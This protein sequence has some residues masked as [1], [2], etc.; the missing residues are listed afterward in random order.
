MVQGGEFGRFGAAHRVI[1]AAVEARAFPAA[2]VEV[3]DA[4]QVL[5]SEALGRLTFDADAPATRP[6]TVFDLASLTKVLS[7]TSIVMQEVERGAIGLDEP[8]SQ[9]IPA[10]TG[11]DR[12]CVTVRDLLAHSSGLPAHRHFYDTMSGRAAIERAVCATP[13]EYEPGTR[14][15]YSDLGFM[16]LGFLLEDRVPLPQRFTALRSQV[17]V[18]EDLQF[19]PPTHWRRRIAPTEQ[20]FRRQVVI[21]A[22][23][24]ENA[25]ALGGAAGHAGLFGT[26]AAVGQYARHTLQVLT[27]K[28]GAFQRETL[29]MFITKRSDVPGSSRALGWDTMLPTSSCGSLMS[30]RSFGHTGFT[31]TSVW[32]DP[33]RGLYIVLLT[34]RVHPSSAN[35]AI[36][37]VRPAFHDAVMNEI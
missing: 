14:S 18:V 15:I 28:V 21:G 8:V 1:A 6:D 32:I 30:P 11:A 7:T 4:T 16:L 2:T 22:V 34:N 26:A 24:D 19:H 9:Y 17:G 13:L 31:G 10:W 12:A 5:W 35:D 29:E 3:G 20:P 33:D 25:E 23:G 27:G 36:R 37:Q